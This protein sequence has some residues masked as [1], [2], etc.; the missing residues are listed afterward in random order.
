MPSHPLKS[1]TLHCAGGRGAYAD[2]GDLALLRPR[3]TSRNHGETTSYCLGG[4]VP[5]FKPGQSVQAQAKGKS[6]VV[7]TTVDQ[8]GWFCFT[9][10]P[11]GIYNVWTEGET[12]K[13]YDRRGP[14][15]ELRA[16][17]M[18]LELKA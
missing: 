7:A 18:T 2:F 16:D 15:V 11:E 13:I 8:R 6:E 3:A 10:L 12:A 1:I 14:L 17:V 5:G 4:V 9:Q